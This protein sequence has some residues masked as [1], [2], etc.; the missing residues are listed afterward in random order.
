MLFCI[1]S[2]SIHT[3]RVQTLA[4]SMC[5]SMKSY[6]SLR[7]PRRPFLLNFATEAKVKQVRANS[8]AGVILIMCCLLPLSKFQ[9]TSRL[10]PSCVE[11]TL[12][13]G[14]SVGFLRVLRF[15]NR[16]KW[17]IPLVLLVHVSVNSFLYLNMSDQWLTGNLSRVYLM[18]PVLKKSSLMMHSRVH[19]NR[20]I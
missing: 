15:A 2:N 1:D 14:A 9:L 18:S 5:V 8:L 7:I 10:R 3:N 12:S 19:R 6:F 4:T 20:K 16:P 17:W 11:F 13:T